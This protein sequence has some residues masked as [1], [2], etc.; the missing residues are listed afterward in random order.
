MQ[1]FTA[2]LPN[3]P[4]VCYNWSEIWGQK[5]NQALKNEIRMLNSF[6]PFSD[7]ISL[8]MPTPPL[9]IASFMQAL[10]LVC[11]LANDH[12]EITPSYGLS[13]IDSSG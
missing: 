3:E 13:L 11:L 5:N 6:F 1:R 2:H 9:L 8:P 10:R 12:F 7:P 4:A